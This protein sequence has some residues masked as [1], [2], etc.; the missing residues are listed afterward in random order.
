MTWG[1]AVGWAESMSW[2]MLMSAICI[3]SQN[4]SQTHADIVGWSA[5]NSNTASLFPAA[6]AF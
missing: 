6:A 5:L 3:H 4:A 1:Q 2:G